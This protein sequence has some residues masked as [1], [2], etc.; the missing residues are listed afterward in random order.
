[1]DAATTS[2]AGTTRTQDEEDKDQ[3]PK[4]AKW[5]PPPP[6][7]TAKTGTEDLP[8]ASSSK[9]VSVCILTSDGLVI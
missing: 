8:V 3:N 2:A 7:K 4:A 6:E 5:P 1:M 9:M